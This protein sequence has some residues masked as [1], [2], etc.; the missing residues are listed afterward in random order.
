VVAGVRSRF[1]LAALAVMIALAVWNFAQGSVAIGC[2]CLAIIAFTT[3]ACHEPSPWRSQL[4]VTDSPDFSR[5]RQRP[6]AWGKRW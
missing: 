3:C 6:R 2:A 4:V 5:L 1:G